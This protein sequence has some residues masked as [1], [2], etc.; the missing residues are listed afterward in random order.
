MTP[1]EIVKDIEKYGA[2]HAD[3]KTVEK[4]LRY[5]REGYD[6]WG[7]TTELVN[8]KVA[9]I[10]ALPGITHEFVLET[11][12]LLVQSPKYE[13]TVIAIRLLL[14]QKKLWTI[15]TFRTVEKW[16]GLG[17]TNWAET[18]YICGE[19]MNLFF[20][21]K[22]IG[23]EDIAGW[24]TSPAK[25]QRRA[26]AVALVKPMKLSTDFNPFYNF[27]EPMMHDKAREVHQGLGW[28]LREMWKKQP[29]PTEQFLLK[30]RT[31]APRLIFQ[32]ATEKMTPENKHRF[33]RK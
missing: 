25:F 29:E 2:K 1:Q 5:F 14:G 4:Y 10:L 33:R 16:F 30:F 26:S 11:T 21:R 17:I 23:M 18:D 6:G 8:V 20:K 12:L 15:E 3:P 19:L 7:M 28:L 31:T 22:L 9:E 24:R 32:Y 27:I 13:A